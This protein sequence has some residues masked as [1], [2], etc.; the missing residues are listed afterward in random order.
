MIRPLILFNGKVY[1]S[2]WFDGIGEDVVIR[3]NGSGIMDELNLMEYMKNQVIP[4]M[5]AKKVWFAA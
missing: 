1:L 4:T 2:S 5:V 3:L